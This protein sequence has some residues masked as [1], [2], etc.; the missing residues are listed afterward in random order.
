MGDMEKI[1]CLSF[2]LSADDIQK[3]KESFRNS[4]PD[5]PELEL[6]RVDE[7]MMDIR[8]G[9]LLE[10]IERGWKP[11]SDASV[12]KG[13][14]TAALGAQGY[15]VMMV[16]THKHEMVLQMMRSF[17]AVLSDPRDLIFAVI[18]ETARGWTFKEYLG[19]LVAE[20]ESMKRRSTAGH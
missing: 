1:L 8:V 6:I 19:H 18:T 15:R 20:H 11:A 3:G 17:K 10:K 14:D 13:S 4:C 16:N 2:G 12:R 5:P 7:T 9:E